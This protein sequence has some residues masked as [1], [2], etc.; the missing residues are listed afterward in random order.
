MGNI[1]ILPF[2]V[3]GDGGRGIR[4]P[5]RPGAGPIGGSSHFIGGA[6]EVG[7]GH[8]G[9]AAV[10]RADDEDRVEVVSSD[11]AVE[12]DVDEVEPGSRAPVAEQPRLDVLEPQRLAQQRVV[13]QVD[14]SDR[15]V[16]RRPPVGVDAIELLGAERARR[17][18]LV[19]RVQER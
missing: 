3:H 16:V 8:H 4:H 10:A 11:R 5:R 12:V 13:Q 19:L 7:V 14:L 17:R 6:L 15:E 2:G 9:R 18:L 1:A